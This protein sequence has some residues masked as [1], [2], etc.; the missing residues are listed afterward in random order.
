MCQPH[1]AITKTAHP[2]ITK[3]V[4]SD[5]KAPL[6]VTG[7]HIFHIP[8]GACTAALTANPGCWS[9]APGCDGIIMQFVM[10]TE[11]KRLMFEEGK[12]DILDLEDLGSDA[13]YFVRGD[14]YE[15]QLR[16]RRRVGLTYIGLNESVKPLNDVRVRRASRRAA[17]NTAAIKNPP[18]RR[19]SSS[20][21]WGLFRP[22]FRP[23]ILF[24][25]MFGNTARA[26]A[27]CLCAPHIRQGNS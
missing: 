3:T 23:F 27:E 1:P 4:S 22:F 5:K 6:C 7:F 16:Y 14:I 26:A 20:S 8:T 11:A 12:L 18:S 21:G 25:L 24:L 9:G 10:D 13:E 15:K 19:R 2:A 17:F